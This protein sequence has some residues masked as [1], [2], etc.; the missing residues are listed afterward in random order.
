MDVDKLQA[1]PELD[2]LVAEKVMGWTTD[3][4]NGPWYTAALTFAAVRGWSPSTDIAAAW[5]VEERIAELRIATEYGLAL[6]ELCK[7]SERDVPMV[8][9]LAHASPL[10]RCWAALNAVSA[11]KI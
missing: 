5:E 10:L 1:G 3:K 11:G 4:T 6:K 2:R 8:F 9:D 7:V